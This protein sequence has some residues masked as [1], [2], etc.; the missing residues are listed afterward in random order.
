MMNTAQN[1]WSATFSMFT[2][3][4][5]E[6]IKFLWLVGEVAIKKLLGVTLKIK[7]GE[8]IGDLTPKTRSKKKAIIETT[9]KK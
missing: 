7:I 6:N 9:I 3:I 2:R 5:V 4:Q 8:T 1:L